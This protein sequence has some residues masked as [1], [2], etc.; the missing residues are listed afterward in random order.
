MKA[1][2]VG[3]YSILFVLLSVL[4]SVALVVSNI[5][6]GKLWA[7]PIA[8]VTLTAGVFLFPVVYIIGDV[9]PE[10]YGLAAARRL[11]LIG[12]AANLF[13]VFFFA[14]TLALPYPPFFQGQAAFEAVL[15]F[16]PRLLFA[17]FVAYLVGTNANAWMMVTV[18]RLTN[19]RWLW[20][21]TISSTIVGESIDSA[22]FITI[23]F[24]GIVPLDVLPG[25]IIAQAT[26]KTLYEILATPLTYFVVSRVKR[27]E[28]IDPNVEKLAL[29][30]ARATALDVAED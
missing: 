18:K 26:F 7:T 22:I 8:G 20:V 24:Y 14:L 12:F 16:T 29:T 27:Y 17:S 5:I 25:M 30:Y 6:A 23:A 3:Q 15:G 4:F 9:V 2:I 21:R 28:G 13:V 19:A 10:C 11:I 1:K